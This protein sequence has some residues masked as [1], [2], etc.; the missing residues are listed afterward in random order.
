MRKKN[1]LALEKS[2]KQ[3][4]N[5]W[6]TAFLVMYIF[7][8]GPGFKLFNLNVPLPYQLV[9]KFLPFYENIRV[10][11]RMFMFAMLAFSLLVAFA[12]KY[13][14][15]KIKEGFL[16]KNFI[17]LFVAIAMLEFWVGP[18]KTMTLEY[19]P[20][21]DRLAKEQGSFKILEIPGS[22]D[23]EFASYK[24]YTDNI[25]N[26]LSLDGMALARKNDGQF[27]LQQ[28][29]PILKQLLYTLP[30]GNDPEQKENEDILRSD[31]FANAT[32]VLNYYGVKYITVSKKYADEKA[33]KNTDEFIRKY[34]ALDDVY[35][36][37]YL[38]AYAVSTK[39]PGGYYARLDTDSDQFSLANSPKGEEYFS[40]R[41]GSG[42]EMEVVNMA[43]VSSKMVLGIT[44]KSS[45]GYTLK[46]AL[47]DGKNETLKLTNN[48][49]ENSFPFVA[50]LGTNKI[51]F[52][53]FDSQNNEVSLSAKGKGGAEVKELSIGY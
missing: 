23:Y 42:A 47:P 29:T 40:R 6:W 19:S 32:N 52:I 41:L 27:D 4:I 20:F 38:I 11:G 45:E 28:S 12:I 24:L 8:W 13:L 35:E 25:H 26:K 21:Y 50:N 53:L 3:K 48:F 14:Q 17:L 5:L 15:P 46:I 43:K 2:E 10:T 39:D 9:Y 49:S 7:S 30:K 31:N 22:T 34:V 37:K 18:L 16:R 36:D 1:K 44:A 51:K 33:Q